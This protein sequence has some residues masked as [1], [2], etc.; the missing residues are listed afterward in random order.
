MFVGQDGQ[1]YI[2]FRYK[3]DGAPCRKGSKNC[4]YGL[5]VSVNRRRLFHSDVQYQWNVKRIIVEPV[6]YL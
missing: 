2:S 5:S 6:R 4:H 3:V 1:N